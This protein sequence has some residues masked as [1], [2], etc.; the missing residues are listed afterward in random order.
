MTR[1][2]LGSISLIIT[3]TALAHPTRAAIFVEAGAAMVATG[4]AWSD[5]SEIADRHADYGLAIG[6]RLP[7][8]LLLSWNGDW[9]RYARSTSLDDDRQ[10]FTLGFQRSD[11]RRE[12]LFSSSL[13]H[14]RRNFRDEDWLL[15]SRNTGAALSMRHYPRPD[16]SLRLNLD[17][18]DRRYPDYEL[19][20]HLRSALAMGTNLSLSTGS[21]IDLEASLV[22][23]AYGELITE[24]RMGRT[25]ENVGITLTG[26]RARLAQSLGSRSGLSLGLRV[27]G[28]TDGEDDVLTLPDEASISMDLLPY[29]ERRADLGLKRIFGRGV[30]ARTWVAWSRRDYLGAA[31]DPDD[32][33]LLLDDRRDKSLRAGLLVWRTLRRSGLRLEPSLGLTW[34]GNHSNDS[35]YDYESWE[36]SFGLELAY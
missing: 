1:T 21:S 26:L 14:Q 29:A 5:S 17:L 32:P 8:G 20:N 3:L 23:R 34:V 7:G 6:G 11:R 19:A 22:R 4:N 13:F 10:A 35:L 33:T 28:V 12:T 18:A 30:T 25:G 36:L 9:R 31:A 24:T 2:I 15:D 27:F 16:L